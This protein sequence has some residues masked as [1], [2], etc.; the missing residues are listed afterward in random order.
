MVPFTVISSDNSVKHIF[1]KQSIFTKLCY[2]QQ[3][4][5]NND[6]NLKFTYLQQNVYILLYTIGSKADEN[7]IRI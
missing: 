4:Q 1:K 3:N 5:L 2:I 6:K 7:K